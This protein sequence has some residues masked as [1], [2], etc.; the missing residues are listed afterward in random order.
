[1]SRL[2][3]FIV[4]FDGE[5]VFAITWKNYLEIDSFIWNYCFANNLVVNNSQDDDNTELVFHNYDAFEKLI[6]ELDQRIKKGFTEDMLMMRSLEDA[7]Y[8]WNCIMDKI[9]EFI[10]FRA[11][12]Y[13]NKASFEYFSCF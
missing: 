4:T 2:S 8:Q 3:G 13:L 6:L 7:K 1:M 5:E 11:D 10:D 12:A 9:F